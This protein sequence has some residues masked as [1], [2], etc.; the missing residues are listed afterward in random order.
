MIHAAR[1]FAAATLR[2][3]GDDNRRIANL[4]RRA[5]GRRLEPAT[6]DRLAAAL[7]TFRANYATAPAEA[8]KLLEVGERPTPAD[9]PAA[10]LAAYTMLASAI[11][12]LDATISVD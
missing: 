8:G 6:R 3:A 5:T 9:L 7:R 4:W 11:L 12:N 10:E 2:E 1:G